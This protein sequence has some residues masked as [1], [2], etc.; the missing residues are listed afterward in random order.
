M[1][2]K[3]AG[4]NTN[5]SG[6]SV[7]EENLF[8]WLKDNLDT[9]GLVER[10]LTKLLRSL[11]GI[12]KMSRQDLIQDVSEEAQ[13]SSQA[14]ALLDTSVRDE[15]LQKHVFILELTK[16]ACLSKE[17][18]EQLVVQLFSQ[19]GLIAVNGREQ[20]DVSAQRRPVTRP[21]PR[22]EPVSRTEL[23]NSYTVAF[24]PLTPKGAKPKAVNMPPVWPERSP[25]RSNLPVQPLKIRGQAI[26]P[27]KRRQKH[28]GKENGGS[29]S[30]AEWKRKNVRRNIYDEPAERFLMMGMLST[31]LGVEDEDWKAEDSRLQAQSPVQLSSVWG[32][33]HVTNYP[34]WPTSALQLGDT[35]GYSTGSQRSTSEPHLAQQ[36]ASQPCMAQPDVPLAQP[37]GPLAQPEACLAQPEVPLAQPESRESGRGTTHP[38]LSPAVLGSGYEL[39]ERSPG[40]QFDCQGHQPAVGSGSSINQDWLF[41]N[42]REPSIWSSDSLPRAN[43]PLNLFFIKEEP[44]EI[45]FGEGL[46][47]DSS[48]KYRYS[49]EVIDD[50]LRRGRRRQPLYARNFSGIRAQ[51]LLDMSL[52]STELIQQSLNAYREPFSVGVVIKCPVESSPEEEHII[53]FNPGP[54]FSLLSR[55]GAHLLHPPAVQRSPFSTSQCHSQNDVADLFWNRRFSTTFESL[56]PRSHHQQTGPFSHLLSFQRDLWP[57][58]SSALDFSDPLGMR[59]LPQ[60]LEQMVDPTVT[61]SPGQ[62]EGVLYSPAPIPSPCD[63]EGACNCGTMASSK[64]QQ[65]VGENGGGSCSLMPSDTSAFEE[66]SSLFSP[67]HL[68]PLRVEV[69]PQVDLRCIAWR[70]ATCLVENASHDQRERMRENMVSVIQEEVDGSP[71]TSLLRWG[72]LYGM[73]NP[74]SEELPSFLLM[75][76]KSTQTR[77][78]KVSSDGASPGPSTSL[79]PAAMVYEEKTWK[80]MLPLTEEDIRKD[81]L[82]HAMQTEQQY[83]TDLD[84]AALE[85]EF[86]EFQVLSDAAACLHVPQNQAVYVKDLEKAWLSESHRRLGK[87]RVRRSSYHHKPCSFYLEGCCYRLDCKFSHDISSITCQFWESGQCFKGPLCPFLHG[88]GSDACTSTA[89]AGQENR[90]QCPEERATTEE[91]A[92]IR[93]DVR[94][95]SAPA[96]KKRRSK[97]NS[98]HRLQLPRG[99]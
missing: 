80:D 37:E 49:L 35:G 13:H 28:P 25:L 20:D 54:G 61:L 63:C 46:H 50:P 21:A 40:V 90:L 72:D 16:V 45:A 65:A 89:R 17:E 95:N 99:T 33:Q 82:Y 76:S 88:Y 34:S 75:E 41:F 93:K 36:E 4:E 55:A 83:L 14:P 3:P 66:V 52:S 1:H 73:W 94:L 2:D 86:A 98:V 7:L 78:S 18:V 79:S 43:W 42:G 69:P 85:A 24:P 67:P 68:R 44:E 87:N 12:F 70:S 38:V 9:L 92:E 31:R 62:L 48:E 96:S 59:R 74:R 22:S 15:V 64:C 56:T 81:R 71:E 58:S 30:R 29:D 11:A 32:P 6:M 47:W 77:D 53:Q 91:Q 19:D 26:S 5:M 8:S 51:G 39:N 97:K 84:V 57:Q 27:E 10:D 23:E 60:Q